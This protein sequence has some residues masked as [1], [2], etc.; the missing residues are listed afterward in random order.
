V[1]FVCFLY[2]RELEEL[3]LFCIKCFAIF[4]KLNEIINWFIMYT[5]VYE[6]L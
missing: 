3:D 5:C 2:H 1:A 4:Y 6:I